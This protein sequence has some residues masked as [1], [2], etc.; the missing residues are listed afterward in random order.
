[1]R[2]KKKRKGKSKRKEGK[3]WKRE[4]GDRSESTEKRRLASTGTSSGPWLLALGKLRWL[5][6]S[7]IRTV[8]QLAVIR[9]PTAGLEEVEKAKAIAALLALSSEQITI[10][11]FEYLFHILPEINAVRVSRQQFT[12]NAATAFLLTQEK[13]NTIS[14]ETRPH[15]FS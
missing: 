2:K 11:S 1:M 6:L 14:L 8:Q 10:E 13:H 7:S 12:A 15:C 3:S 4:G 9:E 5:N